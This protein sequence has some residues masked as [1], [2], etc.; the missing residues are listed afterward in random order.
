[1]YNVKLTISEH[2]A[3]CA[4]VERELQYANRIRTEAKAALRMDKDSGITMHGDGANVLY[5]TERVYML[6]KLK[7]KLEREERHHDD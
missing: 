6:R 4:L 2:A 3:L 1:M 7:A 5:W